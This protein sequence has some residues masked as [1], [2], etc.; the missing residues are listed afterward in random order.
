M[1]VEILQEKDAL[2]D[3][4]I[5]FLSMDKK[6][7]IDNLS[8][9]LTKTSSEYKQVI[10]EVVNSINKDEY[11][12]A[13]FLL[14]IL[15]RALQDIIK[16]K[17]I[18]GLRDSDLVI[19]KSEINRLTIKVCKETN[20]GK[21]LRYTKAI[22]DLKASNIW[23]YVYEQILS[24]YNLPN[25]YKKMLKEIRRESNKVVHELHLPYKIELEDMSLL[26]IVINLLLKELST[27]T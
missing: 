13:Y 5:Q 14:M 1:L 8:N 2:P 4:V 3:D 11:S 17:V 6:F 18:N 26:Y 9:L 16:N 27:L 22:E 7:L 12:K 21:I 20:L 19:N 10:C 23:D 25:K 15:Q 24:K